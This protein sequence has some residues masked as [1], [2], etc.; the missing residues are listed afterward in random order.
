M[1]LKFWAIATLALVLGAC[2]PAKVE[3]PDEGSS[4]GTPDTEQPGNSGLIPGSKDDPYG[5]DYLYGGGEIAEIHITVSLDEWNKL[6]AMYDANHK[7]KQYVKGDLRF[8]KGED[9]QIINGVGLR[10]RGNTSRRRPEVS[11]GGHNSVDTKWQHCHFGLKFTE[12]T[13]DDAHEIAGARN[14]W[15]KWFKEDPTYT[16]EV[17]CYDLFRRAGV[18][19]A[20]HSTYCRLWL[21]VE[22]DAKETYYGVYQMIEPINNRYLKARKSEFGSA[23]GN[24]WKCRYGATLNS[25]DANFGVDLG[26]DEEYT[27][28]LKSDD[29]DFN[30]AREQLQDFILKVRGKTGDSFKNWI[31]QV[32]DVEFLLKTYAVNVTVGMWDDY[33]NNCNNYYLYFTTTDKYDYKFFFIPY[34]YDNTLG[35]SQ[36]YDSGKQNPFQWGNDSNPLIYKILQYDEFRQLYKNALLELVDPDKALFYY[37]ASMKRISQWQSLISDYVVNDTGEDCSIYD[38]PASWG[39]HNEYRIMEGSND[40]Q[41]FFKV[42]TEAILNACK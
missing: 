36:G 37:D 25:I 8:V 39:N 17:Y 22:G 40:G 32:C 4:S 11:D 28:E 21:K 38:K 9:E 41:N 1:R 18:W 13:K 7:T 34:D 29:N 19:T 42:R 33:W 2:E 12:Y 27:Y 20:V 35:T 5:I 14:V 15:L 31:S 26:G 24:L 3:T 16:R 6:L 10:L 30:A 23:D